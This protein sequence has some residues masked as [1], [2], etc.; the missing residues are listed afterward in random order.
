MIRLIESVVLGIELV[1]VAI[2]AGGTA[3]ALGRAIVRGLQSRQEWQPLYR[4]TRQGLGRVLLL[5]LEVLIAADI[6]ATVALELTLAN[7]GALGLL[8]VVRTFLSW[9]IEVEIDGRWPW[10][11]AQ[12]LTESP[13]PTRDVH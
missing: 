7:V 11:G 5:G 2:L 6:I 1:A 12:R 10:Q 13:P 9:A 3:W 8:V 4:E